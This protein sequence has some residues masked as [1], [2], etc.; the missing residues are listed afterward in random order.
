LFHVAFICCRCWGSTAR[1]FI[2]LFPAIL[3]IQQLANSFMCR[4]IC[5]KTFL[6]RLITL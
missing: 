2:C 4:S 6:Q 3:G 1:D 5:P